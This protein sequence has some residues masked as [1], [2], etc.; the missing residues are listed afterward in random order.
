GSFH[1]RSLFLLMYQV[2]FQ[3]Q[4][5]R[6]LRHKNKEFASSLRGLRSGGFHR[7]VDVFRRGT[8]VTRRLVV[9]V[10]LAGSEADLADAAPEVARLLWIRRESVS[11]GARLLRRRFGLRLSLRLG[12]ARL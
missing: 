11:L 1:Q 4:I 8:H 10:R 12:L 7:L 6:R 9:L 5:W 2:L 3:H